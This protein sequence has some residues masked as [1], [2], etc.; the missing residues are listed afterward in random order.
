MF[1][2]PP[3]ETAAKKSWSLATSFRRTR[4]QLAKPQ[5]VS[6]ASVWTSAMTI[7]ALAALVTAAI[8][9]LTADEKALR[10]VIASDWRI[11]EIMTAVTNVGKSDRYLVPAALLFLVTAFL[12]WSAYRR[13]A[14]MWLMRFYGQSA[15]LFGS[16]AGSGILVNIVKLFIGRARP[17]LIDSVGAIHFEPFTP[18]Y[19]FASMPSGHSTTMG[20]VT[21]A[22]MLWFPKLRWLTLPVGFILAA[23]RIA[24]KAHYPSDVV[25]GFAVGFLVSLC[26]ARWLASRQVV[27]RLHNT[28]TLPRIR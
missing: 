15:F 5:L 10:A 4:A 27:F 19:D 8:L 2:M 1:E 21:L 23:T 18:G 26:F 20:A 14:K 6:D 7:I 17:K 11:F 3:K 22:L 24:A 9:M 25:T 12:D 16:V 13:S 28:V